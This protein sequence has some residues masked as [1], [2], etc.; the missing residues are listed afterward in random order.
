M[1]TGDKTRCHDRL[2][3]QVSLHKA[4]IAFLHAAFPLKLPEDT[5]RRFVQCPRYNAGGLEIKSLEQPDLRGE[6][7]SAAFAPAAI[8]TSHKAWQLAFKAVSARTG[9]PH[10][11]QERRLG[12]KAEACPHAKQAGLR[13]CRLLAR[14]SGLL[15]GSLNQIACAHR[16][17]RLGMMFIDEDRSPLDKPAPA[18]HSHARKKN[19]QHGVQ[20]LAGMG[21]IDKKTILSATSSLLPWNADFTGSTG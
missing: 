15:I 12:E 9:H 16:L 6:R 18:P 4:C 10:R 1:P 7:L 19:A 17:A 3:L 2:I 13:N 11:V 14:L 21:F 20:T 8:A 5:H